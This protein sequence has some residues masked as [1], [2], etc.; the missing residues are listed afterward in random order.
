[1]AVVF[2][3]Q[4]IS[5]RVLLMGSPLYFAA[6][7]VQPFCMG[8]LEETC[9][10]WFDILI[11]AST[12]QKIVCC[13]EL[14]LFSCLLT[15]IY[16]LIVKRMRAFVHRCLLLLWSIQPFYSRMTRRNKLR[17]LF[18]IQVWV[19]VVVF[20]R[21]NANPAFDLFYP[22]VLPPLCQDGHENC[23]ISHEFLMQ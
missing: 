4:K 7:P 10:T 17:Y 9:R 5:T 2:L 21:S 20:R 23:T 19:K 12:T 14:S 8:Y 13:F 11:H 16:Q 3:N 1:M 15:F 22:R 18:H 6:L